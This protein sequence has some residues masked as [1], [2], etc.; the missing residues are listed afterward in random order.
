MYFDKEFS[1]PLIE[2]DTCYNTGLPCEKG[3]TLK[4]VKKYKK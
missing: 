1:H 4:Y 2:N 3:Q